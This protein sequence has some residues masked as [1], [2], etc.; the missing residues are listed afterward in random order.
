MASLQAGQWDGLSEGTATPGLSDSS[1]NAVPLI[2]LPGAPSDAP[3]AEGQTFLEF[4]IANHR[5][6]KQVLCLFLNSKEK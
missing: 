3:T 2:I 4:T 5:I 1:P 6:K